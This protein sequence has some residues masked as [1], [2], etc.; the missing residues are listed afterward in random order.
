MEDIAPPSPHV[1]EPCHVAWVVV[2]RPVEKVAMAAAG[3]AV[4]ALDRDLLRAKSYLL[5]KQILVIVLSRVRSVVKGEL[6]VRWVSLQNSSVHQHGR[7][8]LQSVLGVPSQVD[9]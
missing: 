7:M 2:R 1:I 4:G 5:A 3:A 9:A 8:D 6:A